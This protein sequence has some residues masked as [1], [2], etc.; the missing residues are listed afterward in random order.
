MALHQCPKDYF[1]TIV[2][3]WLNLKNLNNVIGREHFQIP[4]FED[5]ISRLGAKKYFTVL[6]QKDS[7]W[8]M[9]LSPASLEISLVMHF[10][11]YIYGRE[12]EV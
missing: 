6:D 4:A 12:V 9:T 7:Y 5:V 11:H 3:L 1:P 10:H 8:Q 2:G